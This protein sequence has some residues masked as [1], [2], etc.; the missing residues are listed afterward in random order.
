[1]IICQTKIDPAGKRTESV[2]LKIL[3]ILLLTIAFLRP[4]AARAEQTAPGSP[5]RVGGP[6]HYETYKGK[7]L[8]ADITPEYEG[9]GFS[10]TFTFQPDQ[11]L[12]PSP[13]SFEG[14]T[15]QLLLDD[16]QYPAADWLTEHRIVVG[17]LL[18]CNMSVISRGA[19]TPVMFEFPGLSS[20][21]VNPQ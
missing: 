15:H 18:D 6:C 14:K 9:D 21:P 1:M 16:G 11:S 3:P 13:L 7:A 2:W 12:P 5:L 8:I 19:C 10:V 20:P 17:T 4:A